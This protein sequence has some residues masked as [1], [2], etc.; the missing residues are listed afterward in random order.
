M[1]CKELET[2]SGNEVEE[3]RMELKDGPNQMEV[4]PEEEQEEAMEEV[5]HDEACEDAAASLA[6]SL[7]QKCV[8]NWFK[9]LARELCDVEVELL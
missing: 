4:A 9:R 6:C 2:V 7:C 3:K 8:K 1:S 5:E